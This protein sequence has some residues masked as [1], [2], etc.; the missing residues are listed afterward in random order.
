M[1]PGCKDIVYIS[2]KSVDLRLSFRT[3]VLKTSTYRLAIIG[4]GDPMAVLPRGAH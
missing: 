1:F 2:S 4:E 3:R